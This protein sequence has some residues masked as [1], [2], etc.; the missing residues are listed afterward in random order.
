MAVY[1]VAFAKL[2]NPTK[3][4]EYAS[5]ALPTLLAGGGEVVSRGKVRGIAGNFSADTCLIVKF[6]SAAALDA[7]YNSAAYQALVPVR[8]EAM[9]ANFLV[10]EEPA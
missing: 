9:E 5:A 4:Q 6:P 1:L 3:L 7:W 2:K 8:D 10:L